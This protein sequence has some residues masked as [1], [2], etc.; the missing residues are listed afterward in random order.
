MEVFWEVLQSL[1]ICLDDLCMAG[2]MEDAAIT[3]CFQ[4]LF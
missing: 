4:L 2:H 3:L 1:N